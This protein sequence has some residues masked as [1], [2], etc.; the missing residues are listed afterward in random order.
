M[1]ITKIIVKNFWDI[2]DKIKE[3]LKANI[4]TQIYINTKLSKQFGT[5]NH[6]LYEK[7]KEIDC[8][9]IYK[10]NAIGDYHYNS[11]RNFNKTTGCAFDSVL[12]T[13]SLVR[14][15]ENYEQI[16]E[17]NTKEIDYT[18]YLVK[19]DHIVFID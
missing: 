11:V 9:S 10:V 14:N 4:N 19:C 5:Y 16:V 13:W 12:I 7:T 17:F 6:E 1:K 18:H 8:H 3:I 2:P 15:F